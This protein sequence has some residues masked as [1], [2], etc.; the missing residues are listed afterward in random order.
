MSEM[1]AK[2][3]LER[4][5]AVDLDGIATELYGLDPD[6]FVDARDAHVRQAREGGDRALA[7]A[8]GKLRRP[9]RSAWLVN[10]LQRHQA[11]AI[12]ELVGLADEFAAALSEKAGA[13]LKDLT[14]RRRELEN[15]LVTQAESLAVEA[16]AVVSVDVLR[17][18]RET[19]DAAVASPE[20][21]EHVRSGRLAKS[22]SAAGFGLPTAARPD[23]PQ[24]AKSAGMA[25][26]KRA[27]KA[28]QPGASGK[29]SDVSAKDVER[30]AA[31]EDAVATARA[32]LQEASA[33]YA[34]RQAAV[35]AAEHSYAELSEEL[36]QLRDRVRQL[37]QQVATA[38]QEAARAGRR[39]SQAEAVRNR[40][41]AALARAEKKLASE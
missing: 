5:G 2:P 4:G 28:A 29:A 14:S 25:A 27:G 23:T 24:R 34:E 37:D 11:P 38:R 7:Q 41:Q 13:K 12:D 18:V 17:E 6:D 20:V 40:A 30:R 10:L 33:D 31:A 22:V 26:G 16:G 8:V 9:T 39:R 32:A 21:A 36:E 35:E 19:L 1:S 15:Q 3:D